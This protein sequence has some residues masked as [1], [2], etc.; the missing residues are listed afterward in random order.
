[1]VT[2]DFLAPEQAEKARQVDGRADQYSLGCT[3]FKLLTGSAPFSGPA[4][5]TVVKKVLA[6][7]HEPAP[8]IR[9]RRPEVPEGLAAVLDRLLAKDPAGRFAS[10]AE[11]AEALQPFTAGAD[12]G[13]L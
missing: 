2:A 10:A 7:A 12:L 4:Y 1:M 8:P 13:H 11:V 9:Q 6:H 5:D 3:L